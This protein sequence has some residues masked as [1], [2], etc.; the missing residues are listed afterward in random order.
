MSKLSADEAI[1]IGGI[2]DQRRA[3]LKQSGEDSGAQA[4]D[5]NALGLAFSGGGIRS[6]TVSLGIAQVL[7]R[8]HRLLDFDYLSTVSGGGYIGSFLTTLF[9]PDSQRGVEAGTAGDPKSPIGRLRAWAAR[10]QST[11]IAADDMLAVY[12]LQQRREFAQKVLHAPSCDRTILLSKEPK[13][14]VRSPVWWLREHSRY[15]APNGTTDFAEAAFYMIRNWAA[16]LY[17]FALPLMLGYLASSLILWATALALPGN[18]VG[19][20]HRFGVQFSPLIALVPVPAVLAMIAASGFWV[21]QGAPVGRME[22][23]WLG[24]KQLLAIYIAGTILL[25]LPA[26][27]IGAFPEILSGVAIDRYLAAVLCIGGALGSFGALLALVC[28]PWFHKDGFTLEIRRRLTRFGAFMMQMTFVLLALALVDTIAFYVRVNILRWWDHSPGLTALPPLIAS[29]AA[30]LFNRIS[31]LSGD[32]K[33]GIFSF[34]FKN[35]NR[36][37]LVAGILLY[38]VFAVIADVVVQFVVWEDGKVGTAAGFNWIDGLIAFLTVGV[39]MWATGRMTGFINLSSLHNL[40]TTR[41]ARAYLGATNSHRLAQIPGQSDRKAKA[42]RI[43]DVDPKDFIDVE[44]YQKEA[45]GAPLH[46]VNATL[47]ETLSEDGS[48]IANR[49]RKG[50]PITFGP[51]GVFVNAARSDGDNGYKSWTTLKEAKAERLSVGQLCA[52]SG[53]AASAGMGARTSLG[54]AMAL[55]F[56]NVRL[57][58]WWETENLFLPGQSPRWRKNVGT[59]GYLI[60]EM[61]GWYKRRRERVYLTDGGHFENSGVYELLRR[62]TRVIVACD[63]GADPDYVFDD[64]QNLVRKARID[65]GLEVR[66]ASTSKVIE[67]VAEEG[68]NLFLNAAGGKWRENAKS[69]KCTGIALLLE[70]GDFRDSDAERFIAAAR[71]PDQTRYIV[72]IKPSIFPDMSEDLIGYALANPTFPQQTTADQFFDEA[73]WESYRMLGCMLMNRLLNQTDHKADIFRRMAGH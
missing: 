37:A 71:R 26:L 17:V 67:L 47:N 6:A 25:A 43:T 15:L 46:L 12:S 28:A 70:V 18:A 62:G 64:L 21:T 11:E 69:R 30:W 3:A 45:T 16:M 72:W 42:S 54:T 40:Y 7:S 14:E 61:L 20:L 22:G 31:S 36:F 41:L 23:K 34:I 1:V 73:Q 48:D 39:L 32:R 13:H 51:E 27:L 9:T 53:A 52:I 58:Y 66:V 56:A 2:L 68:S 59:Y 50:V 55:T 57:G 38:A 49:D 60:A 5:H 33:G 24:A 29:A 44:L 35:I 4:L 63:N 8:H 10:R 19:E 65:L